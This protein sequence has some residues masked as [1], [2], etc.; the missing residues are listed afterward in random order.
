MMARRDRR[1][2][3]R[4]PRVLALALLIAASV[5]GAAAEATKWT[6]AEFERSLF[7]TRGSRR[8]D[9]DVTPTPHLLKLYA[10]WCGHCK[11]MAPAF[12][13]AAAALRLRG[14]EVGKVD[15]A[16]R[17][18]GG[19]EF[20]G[21]LNVRGFPQVKLF[22][23]TE[24]AAVDFPMSGGDRSSAALVSFALAGH[25]ARPRQYF[26]EV[27]VALSPEG[28]E[29]E[30]EGADSADPSA[31][32][33]GESSRRA[34]DADDADDDAADDDDDDDDDDD[35]SPKTSRLALVPKTGVERWR[36]FFADVALDVAADVYRC[37]SDHKL[38][39]LTIFAVAFFVALFG[40]IIT[41]LVSERLG[42]PRRGESW[43]DMRARAEW[44]TERARRMEK[45]KARK[46]E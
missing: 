45:R 19:A 6:P 3:S 18:R 29:G 11:Q 28:E 12:D 15:C 2:P 23:G 22:L 31:S 13:E 4:A 27:R 7:A 30:T 9:P 43:D 1:L 17:A 39:S 42:V 33:D 16:D 10:P 20:C 44:E 26:R 34:D 36:D 25:A 37:L 41:D 24:D 21:R 32:D 8:K 46:A 35:A 14:M 40:I 38:G 5:A